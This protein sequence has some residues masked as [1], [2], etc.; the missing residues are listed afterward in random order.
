MCRLGSVALAVVNLVL[1]TVGCPT[2][3]MS[4][5]MTAA[6]N[7][8]RLAIAFELDPAVDELSSQG[9][10]SLDTPCNG[11]MQLCTPSGWHR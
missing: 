10:P 9:L 5:P 3:I 11:Q 1:V 2:L 6:R 8:Q 4:C 7:G